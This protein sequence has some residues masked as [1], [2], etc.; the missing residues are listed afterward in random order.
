HPRALDVAER[1]AGSIH[2]LDDRVLEALLRRRAD[3][4]YACDRHGDILS[5]VRRAVPGVHYAK[6]APRQPRVT[7]TDFHVPSSR[8]LGRAPEARAH[9]RLDGVAPLRQDLVS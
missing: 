9:S 1:L 5:S 8:A 6:R 2:A 3:L 7:S 4:Y